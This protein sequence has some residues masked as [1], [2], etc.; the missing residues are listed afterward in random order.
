MDFSI[1]IDRLTG[2][3]EVIFLSGIKIYP[4]PTNGELKIESNGSK[5]ELI[6]IFDM[7][8]KKVYANRINQQNTVV[9]NISHLPAGLYYLKIDGK[10]M[11]VMKI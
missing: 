6:E 2:V 7:T 9:I 4:N 5:I 8:G 11:K 3:D 1:H 10:I